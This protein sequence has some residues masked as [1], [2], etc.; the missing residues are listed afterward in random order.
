MPAPPAPDRLAE[1]RPGLALLL[2]VSPNPFPYDHTW[3]DSLSSGSDPCGAGAGVN[4]LLAD[5]SQ[6]AAS[7]L[8]W[9]ANGG[10]RV[11]AWTPLEATPLRP[12]GFATLP[13]G[14]LPGSSPPG[15]P[16]VRGIAGWVVH[17]GSPSWPRPC[18]P[19]PDRI[20][21]VHLTVWFP[22]PP[23]GPPAPRLLSY[24]SGGP[25]GGEGCVRQGVVWRGCRACLVVAPAAAALAA[26]A[27]ASL[28]RPHVCPRRS[29]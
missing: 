7:G 13:A 2:R 14:V 28:P 12:P 6:R 4:G 16:W 18:L 26:P 9:A 19:Q 29:R 5:S 20:P 8:P 24:L 23:G 21:R 10:S 15:W 27:P 17:S 11:G 25:V 3:S 22:T 1:A